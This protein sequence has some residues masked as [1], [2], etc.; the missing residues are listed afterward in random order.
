[1]SRDFQQVAE[2]VLAR[3]ASIPK[4]AVIMLWH[5]VILS[6]CECLQFKRL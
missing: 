4:W 6:L 2:M 3:A 5:K 1:M